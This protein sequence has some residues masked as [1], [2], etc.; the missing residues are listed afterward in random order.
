[1]KRI[2]LL[3]LPTFILTSCYKKEKTN[4]VNR[5]INISICSDI[6]SFDPRIGNEIPSI[7]VINMLFEG[8]MRVDLD[9]EVKPALAR[10][11]KIS[12]DQ[13]RY[14][15]YLRPSLWSDGNK[16]TAYD[17]EYA[18]KKCITPTTLSQG[19]QHYYLR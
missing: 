9:G 18:W 14:E 2:L 1:M 19:A 4:G 6:R 3:L 5:P 16:V 12:E 15:F 10:K 8:L 11:I 13:K 17:F 7:L